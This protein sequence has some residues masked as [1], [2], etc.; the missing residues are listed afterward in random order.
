VPVSDV[1]ADAAVSNTVRS[2][3]PVSRV[4]V[5]VLPD[6]T[7]S[8]VVAEMLTVPPM[9]NEPSVVDDENAVTVGACVS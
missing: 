5:S 6:W 2:V 4:T 7:A 3:V 1:P 9:P 8:L